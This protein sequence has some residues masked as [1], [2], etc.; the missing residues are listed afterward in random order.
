MIANKTRENPNHDIVQDR[1]HSTDYTVPVTFHYDAS[2]SK[3]TSNVKLER[4]IH[5]E[6]LKSLEP[7]FWYFKMVCESTVPFPGFRSG[8]GGTAICRSPFMMKRLRARM[9]EQGKEAKSQS[10]VTTTVMSL[11]LKTY[12]ESAGENDTDMNL[13]NHKIH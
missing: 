2:K 3:D 13:I 8:P 7:L 4:P 6:A 12:G 11:P 5:P 1:S 9:K 10:D